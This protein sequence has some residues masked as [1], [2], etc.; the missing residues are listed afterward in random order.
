MCLKSCQIY[1]VILESLN[2]SYLQM[3]SRCEWF[4]AS[5]PPGPSRSPPHHQPPP[6]ITHTKHVEELYRCYMI[7]MIVSILFNLKKH[8]SSDLN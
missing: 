8:V 3:N 5:E 4:V 2:A 1:E 6:E 7:Q